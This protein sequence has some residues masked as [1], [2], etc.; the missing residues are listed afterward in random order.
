MALIIFSLTLK[1]VPGTECSQQIFEKL[2]SWGSAVS[3][4]KKLFLEFFDISN[5]IN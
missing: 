5:D 1:V 2:F 4:Q 3:A